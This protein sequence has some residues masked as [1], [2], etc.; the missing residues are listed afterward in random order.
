MTRPTTLF[1]LF[2]IGILH[3]SCGAQQ[4]PDIEGMDRPTGAFN[5][6]W[7]GGAPAEQ[8][9][10]GQAATTQQGGSGKVVMQPV[11]DP[12]TGMT[13]SH[14]PLPDTWRIAQG[15]GADQP[16]ITGPNGIKVFYRAG[17]QHM[18]SNDP[19]VQQAYQ[20]S[21][22][23]MRPPVGIEQLVQELAPA[24]SRRGLR[25]VKQYPL[26]QVAQRNQAYMSKLYQTQPA[27]YE[28]RSMGTEW[29]GG[30]GDPVFMI[31]NQTISQGQSDVFWFYHMQELQAPQAQLAGASNALVYALV[32]TQDNPQQIAAYNNNE[33][34]KA[35]QSWGQHNARMQQNQQAFDQQ[36]AR[37]RATSDAVNNAIMGAYNDRNASMDRNQRQF[38]N[39]IR[40]EN[41]MMRASDGQ[42]F[43]VQAGS[44][45]YWMNN[46]NEYIQSN[47]AY[48]DPN[49]DN[50]LN[51]QNWE[52]LQQVP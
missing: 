52:E 27:R 35:Q 16:A 17:G 20:A 51:N 48:Y 42:Q 9:V 38:I 3:T 12:R 44:D 26:P 19:Y 4:T 36:Q 34:M 15:A 41:T 5:E 50:Y 28:H 33:R 13:S 10:A 46:N 32:N 43:Q 11:V 8:G 18:F 39:T 21:G 23:A 2:L 29:A 7:T 1:P 14:M 22:Q 40:E 24:M 31:V 6:Q 37:H 47:D 30:N 45:Q 25:L 49:A